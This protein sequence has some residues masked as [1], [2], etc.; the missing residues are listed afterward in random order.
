MQVLTKARQVIGQTMNYNFNSGDEESGF[1]EL[2]ENLLATQ[3]SYMGGVIKVE[4]M[5][6]FKK[7]IIRATR[8][9]TLVH[10]FPLLLQDT[11]KIVNDPY[12]ENRRIIIMAF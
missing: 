12:D 11:E 10:D 5:A 6:K 7:L 9:Q 4:E 1:A 3:I 2:K 8:A